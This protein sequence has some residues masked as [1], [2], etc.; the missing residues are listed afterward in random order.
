M[1]TCA[2]CGSSMADAAPRCLSCGVGVEGDVIGDVRRT[3]DQPMGERRASLISVLIFVTLL[4]AAVLV[5][6]QTW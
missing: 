6:L 5:F 4:L 3:V 1:K 2:H